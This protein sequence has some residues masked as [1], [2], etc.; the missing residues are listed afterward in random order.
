MSQS[1][2]NLSW[3]QGKYWW[4]FIDGVEQLL[5][6]FEL[7]KIVIKSLHAERIYSNSRHITVQKRQI[8]SFYWGVQLIQKGCT[9]IDKSQNI[10][11]ADI[12]IWTKQPNVLIPPILWLLPTVHIFVALY[13]HFPSIFK[14]INSLQEMQAHKHFNTIT[15]RRIESLSR[16]C[17]VC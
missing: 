17:S 13:F 2:W 4:S 11:L 1:E 7:S 5:Y 14:N 12:S 15:F 10:K 6:N 8:N 9:F 16:F 3:L